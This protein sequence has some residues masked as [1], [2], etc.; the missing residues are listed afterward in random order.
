MAISE[1][2]SRE[3]IVTGPETPIMD[4]A[5]LMRKYHVGNVVV[6]EDRQGERIPV[7]IVTDRDIV[8]GLVAQD[9]DVE[10]FSAGEV[11][12]YDLTT[13]CED[14]DLFEAIH[15]MRE[16]GVRRLPVTNAR[17]GLVGI[18][19]ME[20]VLELMAEQATDLARLVTKELE[21]ERRHRV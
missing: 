15:L 1:I 2:C 20:D 17:G 18:L 5:R 7:G 3:V 8:V 4:V 11:M 19:A 9:V 13:V 14:D 12:S 6:T 10:A 16:H 21:R